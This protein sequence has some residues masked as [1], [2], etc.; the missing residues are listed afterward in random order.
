MSD[1]VIVPGSY[2]IGRSCELTADLLGV[3]DW[4]LMFMNI[5][6]DLVT[7]D[8]HFEYKGQRTLFP[9]NFMACVF[10]VC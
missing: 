8:I 10:S 6:S 4:C 5:D 2:C 1:E 7:A 3:K 9:L